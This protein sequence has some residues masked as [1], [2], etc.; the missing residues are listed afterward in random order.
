MKKYI[1]PLLGLLCLSAPA[2]AQTELDDEN[3]FH[4]RLSLG[5]DKKLSKG[6]HLSAEQQFRFEDGSSAIDRFQTS[7][8][9]SYKLNKNLKAAVSYTLLNPYKNSTSSFNNPRHRFTA[10]LTGSL[11][12]DLWTFA[13]KESFQLT[14]RSGDFNTYQNATNAMVLKS[15]LSA[16][17]RSF[18][19]FKPYGFLE[20]RNTLNAPAISATYNTATD[21][22]LTSSGSEEGDAGWFISGWNSMYVNR[23][24]LG[25]GCEFSFGKQ[26]GLDV[27]LL[28][29][30]YTD[31]DVDAN[32]SGTKL[33][34]YTVQH[35]I[36]ATLGVGYTFSF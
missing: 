7:L 30:Y 34:S 10:S 35:G 25:I 14:H 1:L 24:R 3:D 11:K 33:K 26:H 6:L 16:K 21:T 5:L 27:Y 23:A 4:T 15:R 31:K 8:G 19:E 22:Y 18:D 29:D 28:T 9:L 32:A 17:Y 20:I 2:F 13:L 12:T 36:I